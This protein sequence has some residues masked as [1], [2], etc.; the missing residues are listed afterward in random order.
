MD[1]HPQIRRVVNVQRFGSRSGFEIPT[2]SLG[3][4]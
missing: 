2:T 1:L 4:G 3:G